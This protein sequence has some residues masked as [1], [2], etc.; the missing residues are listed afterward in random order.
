VHSFYG[1][2]SPR[3]IEEMTMHAATEFMFTNISFAPLQ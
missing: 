1:E 3:K 2:M